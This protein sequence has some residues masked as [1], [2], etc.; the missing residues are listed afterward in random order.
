M[1]SITAWLLT[2]VNFVFVKE[3]H[4]DDP[5]GVFNDLIHPPGG[6]LCV[7]QTCGISRASKL[8]RMSLR[9]AWEDAGNH[10]PTNPITKHIH[11][12]HRT[13]SASLTHTVHPRSSM[14]CPYTCV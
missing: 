7:C 12:P 10:R 3:L 1:T 8:W 11:V 2:K 6:E 14:F 5:G 9:C 13:C 4:G